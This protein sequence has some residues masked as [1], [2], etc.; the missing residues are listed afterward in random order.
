MILYGSLLYNLIDFVK[1]EQGHGCVVC[2]KYILQRVSK[3]IGKLRNV[4]IC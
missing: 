2:H 3:F 1:E 4:I